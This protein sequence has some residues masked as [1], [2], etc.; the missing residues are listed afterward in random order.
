MRFSD[1]AAL[2]CIFKDVSRADFSVSNGAFCAIC[3]NFIECNC[4]NVRP[5]WQTKQILTLISK[6][7]KNSLNSETKLSFCFEYKL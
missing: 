4:E 2:S 7:K 1:S 3:E 6:K 5:K